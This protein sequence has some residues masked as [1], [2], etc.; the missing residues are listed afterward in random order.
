MGEEARRARWVR[1]MEM[2]W[3]WKERKWSMRKWGR[4]EVRWYVDAGKVALVASSS[5]EKESV[6]PAPTRE[7]VPPRPYTRISKTLAHSFLAGLP[8]RPR[9]SAL[10]LPR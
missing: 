9:P 6:P 5:D 4:S 1:M 10:A 2:R 3:S 7:V 8:L